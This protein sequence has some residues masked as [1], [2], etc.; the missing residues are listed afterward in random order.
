MVRHVKWMTG[1]L[2][3]ASLGVAKADEPPRMRHDWRRAQQE[4]MMHGVSQVRM[5]GQPPMQPQAR[6]LPTMGGVRPPAQEGFGFGFE[7]RQRHESGQN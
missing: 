5:S 3:A 2:L 6:P 4:N 7:R 1:V